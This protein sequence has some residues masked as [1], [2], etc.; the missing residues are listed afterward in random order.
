[1]SSWNKKGSTE[2]RETELAPSWR[3]RGRETKGG[4]GKQGKSVPNK[5]REQ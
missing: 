2:E 1:M 3:Q 4:T 5:D